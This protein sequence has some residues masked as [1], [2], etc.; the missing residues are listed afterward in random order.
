MIPKAQ[1]T[2]AIDKCNYIKLEIFCTAKESQQRK[3]KIYG[4]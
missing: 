3:K 4:M 1:T 2:K